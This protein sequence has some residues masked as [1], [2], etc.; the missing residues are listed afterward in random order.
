MTKAR[1]AIVFAGERDLYRC[2]FAIGSGLRFAGALMTVPGLAVPGL[3]CPGLGNFSWLAN[4][5]HAICSSYSLRRVADRITGPQCG[6]LEGQRVS[7]RCFWARPL[8]QNRP[9]LISLILSIREA[10]R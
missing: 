6:P 1:A 10:A 7:C 9:R 2:T 5:R 3:A 4:S 8:G